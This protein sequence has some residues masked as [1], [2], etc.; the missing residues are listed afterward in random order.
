[1]KNRPIHIGFDF[2]DDIKESIKS[3][4]TYGVIVQDP[5]KMGYMTVKYSVDILKNI[6]IEKRVIIETKFIK[7]VN[8][9]S[10]K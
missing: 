7:K 10:I 5:E 4:I 6:P 2:S 1:M 8:I 3:G 9:N